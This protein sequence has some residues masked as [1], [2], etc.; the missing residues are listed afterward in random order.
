[1]SK[2]NQ[3]VPLGWCLTGNHDTDEGRGPCPIATATVGPCSCSCHNGA[4]EPRGLLGTRKEAQEAQT[5]E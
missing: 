1:M 4:T 5:D 2:D 3:T